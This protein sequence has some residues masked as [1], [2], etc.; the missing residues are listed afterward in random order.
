MILRMPYRNYKQHYSDCETVTGS[1]DK[2]AKSIEVVVPDN[3]MKPSGV[4]GRRFSGYQFWFTDNA[5]QAKYCTYRAVSR[6]NA[7]RQ[8]IKTCKQEGWTPCEPPVG[9]VDKI[10]R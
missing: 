2:I 7:M 4:R 3:R 9:N 1:Y 6:E 8:H 5:G 10:F